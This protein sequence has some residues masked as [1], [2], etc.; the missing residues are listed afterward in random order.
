MSQQPAFTNRL[1]NETSPYLRQHAHNPVDWYPWG[2]EALQKAKELDKPI[3]LSIGYSACHWCHVMEHESFEDPKIGE[4]LNEHFICIKVDREER[5][6]LDQIYM[7][8]VQLLTRQGGW[9]MSVF[10]TPDLQPFYGGTYFPPKQLYGRPSF[11][12]VLTAVVDAWENNRQA[13]LEQAG[14]LTKGV[15]QF[16]KLESSSP[17]DMDESTMR[18]AASHLRRVFDPVYG[19]FGSAPKFP[20]SMDVQ[21]LLRIW[22]RFD[23]S[24]ALQ[25]AKKTLDGMAMGGM[26][27]HLGGGFHRYSTDERWL[28]PHFEK[29]LYDNALLTRAYLEAFQATGE[30]FYRRKI[31]ETLAYVQREMTS[32]EGPFYSTQD[33]DSEG[34]E[35]KFF[36]WSKAEV[37]EILG[38]DADLFCSVYDVTPGGNWEETNILHRS[39]KDDQE[40]Q[41]QKM[42]VQNLTAKLQNCRQKLL[43]VRNKRVWPNRDDK[44]LTSWNALMIGSFAAAGRVLEKPEYAQVAE[45]AAHFLWEKM[46]TEDG[47]LYRTYFAGSEPK[48]NGYLEDYSF[49]ID[50]FVTLYETQFDPQWIDKALKLSEVMISQF[51]DTEEGGFFYT[52][53]DHEK[54][55]CRTKDP[56]DSSIPSGNSMAV[57]GLL[58]LFKLTGRK[59]LLEK[60]EKTLQAFSGLL[61][62]APQV[63]G[64]ML[65]ALDFHLGPVDEL[66]VVGKSDEAVEEVLRTIS[67]TFRPNR[68][69]ASLP[70]DGSQIEDNPVALLHG[71]D[72]SEDVTTYLCRD[73]SCQAP[74]VG[75]ETAKE[76]LK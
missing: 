61:S 5:P 33:A 72:S 39:R 22:K 47:R 49:L 14:D 24:N 44:I 30:E 62:Q 50:A 63:G 43:E 21:L 2:E 19:G 52:G 34:V 76:G 40:A 46:R 23:D 65:N 41:M 32:P 66:V 4:Y 69:L 20:H 28:V 29:M 27:D 45:K 17:K 57:T 9:P 67:Q 1:Q 68:V 64:Q 51:W 31:E 75:V 70:P 12:Q 3:F 26:Y 36:V 56:H 35:G 53:E 55:I 38:E 18:E 37:E 16:G 13:V 7:A 10:L 48:L 8:S 73:F 42:E 58:R 60:A 71:K 74:W 54:L 59:G 6:D 15:E 25:M 11:Q